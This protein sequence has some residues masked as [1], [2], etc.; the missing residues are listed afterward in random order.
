[1]SKERGVEREEVNAT[2]SGGPA[3]IGLRSQ[4][5]ETHKEISLAN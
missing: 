1:M 4:Q 2:A 3:A 5:I